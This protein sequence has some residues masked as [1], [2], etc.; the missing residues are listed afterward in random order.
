MWE[1][2]C[3]AEGAGSAKALWLQWGFPF[4]GW[5]GGLGLEQKAVK[6]VRGDDGRGQKMMALQSLGVWEFGPGGFK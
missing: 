4:Q 2:L 3:H 6:E 1:A 5:L